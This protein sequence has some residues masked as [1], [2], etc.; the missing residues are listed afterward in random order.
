MGVAEDAIAVTIITGQPITLKSIFVIT[1]V[2]IP[3]AAFGELI[4]DRI[5]FGKKQNLS[6]S[7]N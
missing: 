6:K 1:L 4:V 2:A 3:F 5:E 7:K